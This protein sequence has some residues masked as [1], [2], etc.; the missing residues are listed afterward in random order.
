MSDIY[1]RLMNGE[2]ADDIAAEF[3]DALNAAVA[4]KAEEDARKAEQARIEAE[5]A[6]LA[7]EAKLTSKRE[8]MIDMV[9]QLMYF[10][11]TY[12]PSLG[13]TV[14]EVDAMDDSTIYAIA[15]LALMALDM[16]VMKASRKLP[17]PF[18][19][20]IVFSKPEDTNTA[21]EVERGQRAKLDVFDEFF[22]TLM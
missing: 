4:Q 9:N 13:I 19:K 18:T 11:A 3:A 1:T 5:A 8:T 10:I 17:N 20:P 12:Y 14:E 16:E 22:K 2:N 21:T 7:A 15:D 6:R